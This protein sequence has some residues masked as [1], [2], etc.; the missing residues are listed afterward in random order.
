[1]PGQPGQ[2]GQ[3]GAAGSGS[4]GGGGGGVGPEWITSPWF[5]GGGGSPFDIHCG[6]DGWISR[7]AVGYDAGVKEVKYISYQCNDGRA[8][9]HGQSNP[10][11][12]LFNNAP[13]GTFWQ[14]GY[15]SKTYDQPAG[16]Q[17]MAVTTQSGSL[18]GDRVRA[19]GP[20][21]NAMSGLQGGPA[22]AWACNSQGNPAP[23]RRYRMYRIDGRSGRAIDGVRFYCRQQP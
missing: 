8:D 21:P 23:G 13:G 15:E 16:F 7:L 17:A 12:L 6:D 1:M 5:G 18:R 2:P 19:M 11:P 10:K 9:W 22:T 14:G 3:P 4:G 20:T